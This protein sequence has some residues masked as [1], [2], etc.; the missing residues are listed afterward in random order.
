MTQSCVSGKSLK[1]KC[2]QYSRT[3]SALVLLGHVSNEIKALG[4]N[5]SETL[6][7]VSPMEAAT[8]EACWRCRCPVP[9]PS[10]P[11]K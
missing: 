2:R 4:T 10:V 11:A 5:R 6:L 7:M 3:F 8:T 1:Q 9:S